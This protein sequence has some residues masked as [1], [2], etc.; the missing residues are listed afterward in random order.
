MLALY[1]STE[2]N[3]ST[4]SQLI[5]FMMFL[6]IRWLGMCKLFVPFRKCLYCVLRVLPMHVPLGGFDR[7]QRVQGFKI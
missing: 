7:D 1:V 5:D 4:K 2:R 6:I 3:N